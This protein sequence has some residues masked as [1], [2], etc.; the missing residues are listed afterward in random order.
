MKTPIT[1]AA[2]LL[3]AL[4]FLLSPLALAQAQDGPAAPPPAKRPTAKRHPSYSLRGVDEAPPPES[5]LNPN[6]VISNESRLS[7]TS[8]WRS[9]YLTERLVGLDIADIDGDGKNELVYV[10]SRKVYAARFDGESFT[11]LAEFALP[12]NSTIISVDLFDTNVDGRSEII[13]SAQ[14]PS[15]SDANSHVL[16]YTGGKTLEVAAL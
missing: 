10:T 8:L 9:P 2:A 12:E 6:F 16:R 11:Q 7:E 15:G 1:L 5:I 13:V 4:V 14:R 3:A